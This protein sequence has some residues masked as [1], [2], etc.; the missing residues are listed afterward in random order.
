MMLWLVCYSQVECR[1]SK[2]AA[3]NSHLCMSVARPP[4]LYDG[5][6]PLIR[7]TWFCFVPT[8]G[9]VLLDQSLEEPLL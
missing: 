9:S 3:R 8:S 4:Y 1:R 7:Y 5:L 2:A 6:E